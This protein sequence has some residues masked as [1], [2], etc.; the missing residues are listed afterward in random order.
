MI[1]GPGRGRRSVSGPGSG[2][3]GSR[4]LIAGVV[5]AAGLMLTAVLGAPVVMF[6]SGGLLTE[7]ST[8]CSSGSGN[9]PAIQPAA[10]QSAR[11]SIPASYLTL[12]QVD[13]QEYKV[14]WVILAGIGKVE[15]DDGQSTLARCAQRC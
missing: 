9:N 8:S 6:A 4:A 11:D 14:P 13:R 7:S 12:F 1:A 2:L 5:C 15:S 3:G 10:S